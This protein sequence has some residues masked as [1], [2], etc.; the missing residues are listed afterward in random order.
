[1]IVASR[2]FAVCLAI[3]GVAALIEGMSYSMILRRGILAGPGLFPVII[4]V[5]LISLSTRKFLNLLKEST[6]DEKPFISLDAIKRHA[7]FVST[8]I[9][10]LILT[11]LFGMVLAFGLYIIFLLIVLERIP[12]LKSIVI[13]V[14]IIAFVLIVFQYWLQIHFISGIIF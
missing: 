6:V 2:I 14:T 4:S 1:M 9:V 7:L 10:C 8:F 13:G 11:Y 12:V 3:M 5:V